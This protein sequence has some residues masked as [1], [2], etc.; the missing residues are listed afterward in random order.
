MAASR[1]TLTKASNSCRLCRYE[2][3]GSYSS[4]AGVPE[5]TSHLAPLKRPEGSRK[6]KTPAEHLAFQYIPSP[7]DPVPP[8]PQSSLSPQSQSPQSATTPIDPRPQSMF[9]VDLHSHPGPLAQQP[10][11]QI[12]YQSPAYEEK[13]PVSPLSPHDRHTQVL[14]LSPVSPA[15]PA[16][17][18]AQPPRIY[19]QLPPQQQHSQH[20]RNLSNLSPLNTNLNVQNMPPMPPMPSAQ[21]GSL[22]YKAP[23]TPIT[24]SSIKKDP[25]YFQPPTSP[26]AQ[27]P[28]SYAHEA[29]SPHNGNLS[30]THKTQGGVF[31]PESA[32]GPNGLDFALHQPGQVAHPNM[33]LS[34]TGKTRPWTSSLCSFSSD[35]ITGFFCPCILYGRTSHRLSQ[36]S[37]KQDPTDLLSYKKANGHCM[38]M[39]LSCGFWWVYPL[40]QRTRV[41]HMYKLEGDIVGDCV[42]GACCCCCTAVQNERE[43]RSREEAKRQ[44]AGPAQ[45]YKSVGQMMYAPQQ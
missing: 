37:A 29:Y 5:R 22:P 32:H 39:A 4:F 43:V 21:A 13:A 26:T 6:E 30:A 12:S 17:P 9:P 27:T 25:S 7:S 23:L 24:P 35:C 20:A 28:R 11:P 44:W 36:K 31:S 41:R 2:V 16:T 33:D 38:M 34:P 40:V 42:R 1:Q 3:A 10:V 14:P 8:L 18:V 15:F 45:G 19:T